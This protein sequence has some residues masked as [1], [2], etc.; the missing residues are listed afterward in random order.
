M[1]VWP[2]TEKSVKSRIFKIRNE[3]YMNNKYQKHLEEAREILAKNWAGRH[4]KPSPHLY[5]HQWNWDSG[6]ISVGYSR[7]I[8][9]RAQ[10]EIRTLFEAQWKNGMV[11]QI[12]FDLNALGGYFPEPDFWQAE[13]SGLV[14]KGKLTSGI[15][16]PPV[17]ATVCRSVF[18]HADD[19]KEAEYFLKEM[20]PK[21]KK[22][23][24][25]FY[26]CR[27]PKE[28]GLVYIRHPWE[29]GVDN[30]P[31]WDSP[32]KKIK[33]E[34]S[35]LPPYE[36]KD[37]SKGIPKEQRPTD[38]EYDRYV[39]LVDLFR[40]LNYDDSSINAEC[41]FKVQDILFNSILNRANKDL[42]FISDV[43][44]EDSHEISKWANKT[45]TA[46]QEKLW[47]D[48]HG[49]FDDYDLYND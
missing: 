42:I 48:E 19:K 14:T 32:L 11:P 22:S 25:Y 35:S 1:A 17:H 21:L 13:K 8:Q 20:Y 29:S 46:I 9:K 24:E 40:R 15:T 47:H 26:T 43:I 4:T 23:H 31:T 27:D 18:E 3:G 44:G 34:K 38:E 2:K 12:V 37:L 5:P 49:I 16:M 7:Y 28:E 30:S 33:V 6:F 10:Q 39:F 45:T 36:R 41:P